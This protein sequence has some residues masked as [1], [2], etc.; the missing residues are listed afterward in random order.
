MPTNT[1][2]CRLRRMARVAACRAAG[3]GVSVLLTAC[4]QAA[5]PLGILVNRAAVVREFVGPS[6]IDPASF[7]LVSRG[8]LRRVHRANLI[9]DDAVDTVTE[10]ER[11]RGV[12]VTDGSTGAVTRV[13]T[14]DY[15]TDFASVRE[16]HRENESLVLLAYPNATRGGTLSV[17]RLPDIRPASRWDE[18]P[19]PS[20]WVGV[21]DWSGEP[22]IFYLRGDQVVL[23]SPDGRTRGALVLPGGHVFSR[24]H[25]AALAAGRTVLL[26]S[27]NGYT[28][29]HAIAV[30]DADG[31]LLFH[32]QEKEHAFRVRVGADGRSFEVDT[33]SSLWRYRVN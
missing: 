29:Y 21:A 27:G 16:V 20:S 9:G 4:G 24:L 18:L 8:S 3:M 32:E 28:P 7:G 25:P 33:R 12:E 1:I 15:L 2:R 30:F 13:E 10:L 19:A 23:R 22:T 11:G 6:T 14:P 17:I 5:T 26:A 31:T